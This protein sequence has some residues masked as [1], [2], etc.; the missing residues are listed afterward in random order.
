MRRERHH[1]N[2]QWVPAVKVCA[3]L[4]LEKN[5]TFLKVFLLRY[6]STPLRLVVGLLRVRSAGPVTGLPNAQ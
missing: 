1:L 3:F 6:L 5:R 2:T 4:E